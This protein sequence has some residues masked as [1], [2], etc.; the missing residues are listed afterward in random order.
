MPCN[1]GPTD[2]DLGAL[3]YLD[4]GD[5]LAGLEAYADDYDA[6][7]DYDVGGLEAYGD[8]EDE[9]DVE[10][11]LDDALSWGKKVYDKVSGTKTKQKAQQRA[12]QETRRA[13]QQ[14]E[15][16][17]VLEDRLQ[18]ERA[19]NAQARQEAAHRRAMAAKERELESLRAQQVAVRAR[20]ER[21]AAE[22]RK[23]MLAWGLGAAGIA[24]VG[25]GAWKAAKATQPARAIRPA[26]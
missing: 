25:Y 6:V 4:F 16:A 23:K 21:V 5:E 8:F 2:D 7:D 20:R 3:T 12:R 22:K 13:D 1:C 24:T 26:A 14:R 15:R 11:L 17:E 10:G 9:G 19:R 18:A